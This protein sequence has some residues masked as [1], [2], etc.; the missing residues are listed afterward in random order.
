MTATL[1]HITNVGLLLLGGL[2]AFGAS[3]AQAQ[4]YGYHRHYRGYGYGGY[5]RPGYGVPYGGV[6]VSP[7]GV[8]GGVGLAPTLVPTRRLYVPYGYR[9]PMIVGPGYYGRPRYYRGW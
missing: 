7:F 3:P 2:L 6:A 4:Y 8:Y 9:R 5:H 1:R